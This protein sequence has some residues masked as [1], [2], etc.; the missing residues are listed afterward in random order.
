M[1]PMGVSASPEISGMAT[2]KSSFSRIGIPTLQAAVF[3]TN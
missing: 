3:T 2:V 1:E